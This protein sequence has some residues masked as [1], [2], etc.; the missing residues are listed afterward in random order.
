MA[1][2]VHVHVPTVPGAAV[3][4]V[5]VRAVRL[6]QGT[7]R[8]LEPVVHSTTSVGDVLR[9]LRGPAGERVC[10]EVLQRSDRVTVAL[11]PAVAQDGDDLRM[12]R[13]A[14]RL[15]EALGGSHDDVT[16]TEMEVALL[17]VVAPSTALRRVLWRVAVVVRELWEGPVADDPEA[18]TLGPVDYEI[19]AHPGWELPQLLDGVERL[20]EPEDALGWQ[21]EVPE[22]AEQTGVAGEAAPTP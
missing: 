18:S 6:P 20:L 10:V 22:P 21:A 1:Q 14:T 19:T 4:A 12:A 9:V 7:V 11:S 15:Q 13:L 3:D 5:R 2:Q 17:A 8:L 16:V